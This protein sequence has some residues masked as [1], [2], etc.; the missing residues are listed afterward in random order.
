MAS[1]PAD[2]GNGAFF[3]VDGD[4]LAAHEGVVDAADPLDR[5]IPL[6]GNVGNHEA[7]FVHVAADQDARITFGIQRGKGIAVGI[8][9]HR[10]GKL[11]DIVDPDLLPAGLEA[12]GGGGV[13]QRLEELVRFHEGRMAEKTLR[14]TRFS[15]TEHMNGI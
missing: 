7:E 14:G 5:E 12:G 11:R 2:T 10:I 15:D 4:A 9:L 6:V 1:S 3:P 13:Q 8:G